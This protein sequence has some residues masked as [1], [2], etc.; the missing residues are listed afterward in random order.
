MNAIRHPD[1]L[2]NLEG[3]ADFDITWPWHRPGGLRA[4]STAVLRVK[5]E[6][7]ALPFVLP[8]L[9]RACDEV[10]VVDNGSTDGSPE[11]AAATAERAGLGHR[12]R[13]ATYPFAVA[14]AGAEHLATHEL[15]VHSLS[16][17]YNWCF[18]QVATRYSWKWDG[19]MVLTTE[20]E[21]SL[22][23]LAWQVGD[24]QSIIRVPRHGLYLDSDSHGYLD[25][26]LRNAEEWGYP[27]GPD[28]VFTKAFEWEIRS[29]PE[30]CRSIGLPHG[31]CVELKFLDSDEFAHWTDPESFATSFRN[32]R[33]RREWAVFQSLR[34]GVVPDGVH[35]ITAPEGVHIVDHV[36]QTWLPRAPRP[37]QVG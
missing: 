36:T 7:R 21:V 3:H 17:F 24:V 33:K 6:A 9:L 26:G 35:E 14:R 27:V 13:Q 5:D 23:D 12:L 8:P 29:T 1:G 32:K 11:V 20:G 2:R 28:F 16:Y 10:L 25:L 30:Q 34:Q 22:G 18:A 37:L 19:D 15:S 4:G 31:L